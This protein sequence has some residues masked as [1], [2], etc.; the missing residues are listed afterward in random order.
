MEVEIGSKY[1]TSISRLVQYLRAFAGTLGENLTFSL[2]TDAT[3]SKLL[4][5]ADF[6]SESEI[7]C[8]KVLLDQLKGWERE[9]ENV[10]RCKYSNNMCWRY[11]LKGFKI[12][13]STTRRR[14]NQISLEF[15][16]RLQ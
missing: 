8:T 12:V 9:L 16:W 7:R 14:A 4:P 10:K 5:S 13:E 2:T 11:F 1:V 15:Q 3:E 6:A